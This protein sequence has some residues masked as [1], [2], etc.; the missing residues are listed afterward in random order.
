MY[1]W[2]CCNCFQHSVFTYVIDCFYLSVKFILKFRLV[3][4]LN[5]FNILVFKDY[6][7]GYCYQ[8]LHREV[9][10]L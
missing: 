6:I 10:D 4:G 5:N 9:K 3:T 8:Y 7:L 2:F 1:I